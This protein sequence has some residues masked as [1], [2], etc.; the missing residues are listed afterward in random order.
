MASEDIMLVCRSGK[1]LG[2]I[3]VS[4]LN[5]TRES[6]GVDVDFVI[7]REKGWIPLD[8]FLAWVQETG[9]PLKA[10]KRTTKKTALSGSSHNAKQGSTDFKAVIPWGFITA[11]ALAMMAVI[12][13]VWVM[14]KK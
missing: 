11:L 12:I 5:P 8:T 14:A 10:A 6:L 1:V 4:E 9:V 2:P 3:P 7:T 13:T